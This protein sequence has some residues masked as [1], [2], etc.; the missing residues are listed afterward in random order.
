VS[1]PAPALLLGLVVA[2]SAAATPRPA[3]ASFSAE[4]ADALAHGQLVTEELDYQKGDHRFVGGVSYIVVNAKAERL[5]AIARD[6]TRF[7]ELFPHVRSA[8]MLG[9][10]ASGV[11]KVHLVHQLGPVS[12]GYTVKIAFSDG[13]MTGR[14]WI[15]TTADNVLEDAWGFVRLTPVDGGARTLVSYGVLFDLGAG[16]LRGLFERRIQRA[17]LSYPRRLADAAAR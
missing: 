7:P 17:A 11:A 3:R 5:S 10:S 14:F 8:T 16:I 6:V 9:V 13:G 2:L 1:R 15:D 4:Q 12:G